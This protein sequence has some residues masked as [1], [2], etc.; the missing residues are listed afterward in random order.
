[1]IKTVHHIAIK[2]YPFRKVLAGLSVLLLI[3]CVFIVVSGT[4]ANEGYLLP[5]VALLGWF[6][7]LYAVATGFKKTLA[8]I[9]KEDGFFRRF[10]K[11]IIYATAWLLAAIC[12]ICML[13]LTYLSY[14]SLRISI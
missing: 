11:R 7:C 1:M 5:S 12:L 13:G 3:F 6:S 4:K 8:P 9:N 2:I 10:K 14:M